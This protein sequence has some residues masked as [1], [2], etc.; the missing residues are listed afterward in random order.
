MA[1]F[2]IAGAS[3]RVSYGW[4]TT[5]GTVSGSVN[6]AFG[7]GVKLNT[8]DID[9]NVDYIYGLGN[10][11]AQK[12]VC[13]EFKGTWGVEFALSDPWWLRSILGGAPADA[14]AA[15]YTHTYNSSTGISNAMT[16]LSTVVGF[17]LDTDSNQ[18]LLGCIVNSMTLTASVGE[19][20]KVSLEGTFANLD[21]DTTLDAL[22]NPVEDP[23]SFGAASF[24]QPNATTIADIQS[25]DMTWNRNPKQI[26]GLGSRIQQKS[27]PTQR[28]W[29]IKVTA[30]YENDNQFWDAALGS[31]TAPAAIPAEVATAEL[32]ISN[33]EAGS[34]TR[35]YVFL[36]ANVRVEK[37]TITAVTDD[38]VKQDI[39]IRARTLTSVVISNATQYA[40]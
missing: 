16:S 39:T 36:F 10:Q 19:Y 20:V 34:S 14:G 32:T 27:V 33:G 6:K 7:Q 8:F 28:E 5:F 22:V 21:K 13:K 37:G 4:E 40:L 3:V 35:S 31:T 9:N 25:I 11:D 38:V 15:P 18:T 23:F 1:N 2:P 24:E 29:N 12:S 30:T 26:Y 17:D